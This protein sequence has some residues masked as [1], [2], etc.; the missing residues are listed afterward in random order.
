MWIRNRG[1]RRQRGS[2]SDGGGVYNTTKAEASMHRPWKVLDSGTDSQHAH[3]SED[4][5]GD[6]SVVDL[7][8]IIFTS[9][10]PSQNENASLHPGVSEMDG[11]SITLPSGHD[12]FG[13]VEICGTEFRAEL[14]AGGDGGF[15]TPGVVVVGGDLKKEG[16]KERGGL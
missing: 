8:P 7:K 14:S 1:R 11:S 15:A 5:D 10:G 13:A 3:D 6:G 2:D 16:E 12:R 4:G 9:T